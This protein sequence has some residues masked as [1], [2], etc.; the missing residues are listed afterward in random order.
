VKLLDRQR[1]YAAHPDP[2]T[3]AANLI[4][5]VVAWNGPL[6]P[7][8]AILLIGR[9]GLPSLGTMAASPFFFAIPW[10]A[11]RSAIAGRAALPLIGTLDAIWCAKLFGTAAGMELF[12]LPCIVLAALLF[13]PRERRLGLLIIA[14]AIAPVLV[15]AASYGIP[16]FPLSP[17]QASHLTSLNLVSVVMLLGLVALQMR[18]VLARGER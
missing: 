2:A 4:A 7:I 14:L 5:L 16:I 1:A 17:G 6:Y 9:A 18:S 15:P 10:L 11:R 8:Y 12:L 3:A 13:R